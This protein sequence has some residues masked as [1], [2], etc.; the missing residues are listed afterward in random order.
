MKVS[1]SLGG[2]ALSAE[3]IR[4]IEVSLG[5]FV[6][7]GIKEVLGSVPLVGVVFN[8]EERNDLSGLGASFRWMS[9][10]EM[11]DEATRCYP[12]IAAA[13]HGYLPVGICLE[14]T[15]DP[16]FLRL[17]DTAI[18]RIPHAAA[19]GGSLDSSQIELVA[20]SI[21]ALVDC[22]QLQR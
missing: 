10:E 7:S 22:A 2:K 13:P 1:E 8:V 19:V 4:R 21:E 20:P 5:L 16:Y 12:G 18:V 9:A 3:D 14:G 17:R 6:P 15:G 11:V